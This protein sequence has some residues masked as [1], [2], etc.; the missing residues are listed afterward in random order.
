IPSAKPNYLEKIIVGS[1]TTKARLLHYFPIQSNDDKANGNIENIDDSWCGW[2]VDNSSI[3]GLTSA[4]YI[5]E[6]DS[7][8]PEVQCPD[9]S[10]GLYIKTKSDKIVKVSIP[11]DHLAFQLGEA[12]QMASRNNLLATPH[13]VK[14]IS[15][16]I[17]NE[18][19]INVISRNT[20]AVFMQPS[21]DEMVGD[22]TFAEFGGNAI[23][24]HY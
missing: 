15:P 22:V 16:N 23:R 4:M 18:I 11:K 12:M 14:G 24:I 21:L 2:H 8:F 10:S 6:S 1:H 7:T 3:T 5:N 20:F 13:M 9:P 19:P 17:K